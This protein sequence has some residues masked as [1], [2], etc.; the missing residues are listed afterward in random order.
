[1]GPGNI[2][3]MMPIVPSLESVRSG[4]W[5][6]QGYTKQDEAAAVRSA[7][8]IG[9]TTV[10]GSF[11]QYRTITEVRISQAFE[12]LSTSPPRVIITTFTS[13]PDYNGMV[14]DYLAKHPELF[15]GKLVGDDI[16]GAQRPGSR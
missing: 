16:I 9:R 6:L 12:G 3:H 10:T 13:A 15:G 7:E 8:I 1:M 11:V 2:P 4:I 5:V 14:K